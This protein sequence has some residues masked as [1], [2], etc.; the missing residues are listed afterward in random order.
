MEKR[1][2]LL[3]LGIVYVLFT[4][5]LLFWAGSRDSVT[6]PQTAKS[7]SEVQEPVVESAEPETVAE[8]EPE[9]VVQPEPVPEPETEPAPEPEP[10]VQP[11]PSPAPYLGTYLNDNRKNVMIRTGPSTRDEVIGK[12]PPGDTVEVVEYIEDNEDWAK[13]EYDGVT[14]YASIA[15]LKKLE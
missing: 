15:Y 7:E 2:D 9:P 6:E 14:G 3:L 11:E 5:A 8:P 1:N 10:V 13:V 12:V 4:I